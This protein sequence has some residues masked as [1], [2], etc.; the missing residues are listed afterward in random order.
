MVRGLDVFREYF[1]AHS[2]QYVLIGG[3]AATYAM[4]GAGLTF[5]AT[6]D[7]DIVLHIEALTPEF[8]KAFWRFVEA[9]EYE[10]RQTSA[11]GKP[12]VYRFVKPKNERFPTMLELFCRAPDGIN[13]PANSQL[14]PI[15][16]DESVASLSAIILDDDYYRF[17]MSG[18]RES[19]G[20]AW[21]GED[22][23]IPLKASAWLDLTA[24]RQ[25]G[26]AIDAD[27]IRKH[28]KDIIRLSQLL[29]PD[30]R[31]EIAPKITDQLSR[32]LGA[33]ATDTSI[34]PRSVGIQFTTAEISSRI[35]MTYG[36]Q[37]ASP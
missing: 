4:E 32:F 21:V 34:D 14:T 11:V 15:P 3:V 31:V 8:G 19:D 26:E 30:L 22:R 1:A 5:R 18:R 13:L 10:T 28:A 25:S 33:I 2:D 17:V 27:N 20:V 23:L 29:A 6:R 35:A 24:R 12:R 36:L 9:G 37:R 7:L 16:L